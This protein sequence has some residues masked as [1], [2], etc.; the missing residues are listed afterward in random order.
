MSMHDVDAFEEEVSAYPAIVVIRSSLQR[1]VAVIDT[2]GSFSDSHVGALSEWV[3]SDSE[4]IAEPSFRGNRLPHWFEGNDIWPGGDPGVIRMVE[5]LND[6]LPF[7]EDEAT[8]TRVGIGVATGNDGIFITTDRQLVEEE[9]LL[10]LAMSG[11]GISGELKWSGHYLV[12][13]WEAD[14]SLVDLTRYPKLARYFKAHQE[15]LGGRHIAKKAAENW[16]RTIDKVNSELTTRLKLLFPDMK[17]TAHPVLDTGNTYPH[18]N[19]YFVTSTVWDLEVLGGILMSKVAESFI[20][21]YCVKMRGGTLRFQA[22]Y[23]RR[24]RVPPPSV[25]TSG[26]QENFARHSVSAAR[27]SPLRWLSKSMGLRATETCSVALKLP[28]YE[29]RVSGRSPK[30]LDSPREPG[31]TTAS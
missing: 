26:D 25:I 23:L 21:A 17:M 2:Q 8:G 27:T 1:S 30:L 31:G 19:L 6:R 24:I 7:L 18:H 9:R 15:E 13:P 5:E 28:D 3:A 16:F 11:D 29:P 22:Q 4:S 14:G 20:S 12:N 10:P